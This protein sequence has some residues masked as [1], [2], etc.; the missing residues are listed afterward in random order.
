M[1]FS[2]R[3]QNIQGDKT[4]FDLTSCFACIDGA[5]NSIYPYL[6]AGVFYPKCSLIIKP[7]SGEIHTLATDVVA[8]KD[9]IVG[10]TPCDID[11]TNVSQADAEPQCIWTH[12]GVDATYMCWPAGTTKDQ[13]SMM[14]R[15]C[16]DCVWF[17]QSKHCDPIPE[18]MA[19]LAPSTAA[20]VPSTA[21]PVSQ[22]VDLTQLES[23]QEDEEDC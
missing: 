6:Q 23:T 14:V 18:D 11:L 10:V 1:S 16:K 2:G 7:T 5:K 12:I 9:R 3:A 20:A 15:L 22:A 19:H 21:V 17:T 13:I 8:Q 4:V